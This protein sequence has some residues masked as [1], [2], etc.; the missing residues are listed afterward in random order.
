MANL[1]HRLAKAEQTAGPPRAA[2]RHYLEQVFAAN[3]YDGHRE[4][5]VRALMGPQPAYSFTATDPNS[6]EPT[7]FYLI[8]WYGRPAGDGVYRKAI[9]L[10]QRGE[11]ATGL[12]LVRVYPGA[13]AQPPMVMTIPRELATAL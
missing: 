4:A 13:W 5:I 1:A 6:G 12:P 2:M 7:T 11:Q 9:P 10:G 3:D 8:S